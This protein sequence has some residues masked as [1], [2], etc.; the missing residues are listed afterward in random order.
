MI[1]YGIG[2]LS[3]L[4]ELWDSHPCVT[5]TWYDD[6]AGEG[7]ILRHIPAHF[8]DLQVRVPPQGKF[9]ELTKRILFVDPQNVA[10]SEEFFLGM[11]IM[12]VTGIRYLIGFIGDQAVE[13]TWLDEKVQKLADPERTLFGVAHKHLQLS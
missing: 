8:K 13:N 4:Q 7:L 2:F 6:D 1:T 3:L 12:V 11:V 5:D 9:P 10:R